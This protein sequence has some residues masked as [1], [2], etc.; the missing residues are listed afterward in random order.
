MSAALDLK[1]NAAEVAAAFAGT[2]TAAQLNTKADATAVEAA[3]TSKA[4]SSALSLKADSAA[5]ATKADT[6]AV[7]ALSASVTAELGKRALTTALT[8]GLAGKADL[9][10]LTAGLAAKADLSALT[11][12]L[13]AKAD[14]SA[15]SA[16]ATIVAAKAD[17]ATV[18]EQVR[19]LGTRL[20]AIGPAT[21]DGLVA[22]TADPAIF[23]STYTLNASATMV[24]RVAVE[25]AT[26][27]T[28]VRAYLTVYDTT[29]TIQAAVATSAGVILAQSAFVAGGGASNWYSWD[30]GSTVAAQPAGTVLYVVFT[31]SAASGTATFRATTS[32]TMI[33]V[34]TAPFIR[35]AVQS[36]AGAMPSPVA[37]AS[38]LALNQ[39]CLVGI[40]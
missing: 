8:A 7:D 37:P 32:S 5:L 16:Q 14:L 11:A 3:L 22:L 31:R 13:A 17:A 10:A 40:S 27:I 29:T 19:V 23:S 33:A 21:R 28:K 1:A 39:V 4:D 18:N 6:A 26:P 36:T 35:A 34:P 20:D 38:M 25:S 2:A 30:L 24:H 9:S 12:G 15:L